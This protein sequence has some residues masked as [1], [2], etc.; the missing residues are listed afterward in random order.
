[1][2]IP[3]ILIIPAV[4]AAGSALWPAPDAACGPVQFRLARLKTVL[5]SAILNARIL[6][7][8]NGSS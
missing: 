1:M 6:N 8:A 4:A 2:K 7:V 5:Q 3:R